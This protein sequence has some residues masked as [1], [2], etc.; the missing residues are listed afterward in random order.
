MTRHSR[1]RAREERNGN[2]AG[3]SQTAATK[4][5]RR[6][7]NFRKT[8]VGAAG[9]SGYGARHEFGCSARARARD[10]RRDAWEYRNGAIDRDGG[11]ARVGGED[12]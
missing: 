3:Q 4:R 1:P 5:F 12:K 2:S 11:A 6:A 8:F 10:A 9:I 7:R